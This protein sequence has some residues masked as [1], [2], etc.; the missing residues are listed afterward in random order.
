MKLT[1]MDVELERQWQIRYHADGESGPLLICR[2][3]PCP[4][5]FL[6][7]FSE[8]LS[9]SV[10]WQRNFAVKTIVSPKITQYCRL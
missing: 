2:F 3:S 9:L 6:P 4:I 5:A 7:S 8:P 1:D 10:Y